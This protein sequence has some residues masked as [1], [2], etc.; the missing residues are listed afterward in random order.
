MNGEKLAFFLVILFLSIAYGERG[1]F[2]QKLKIKNIY[3]M[4]ELKLWELH[5]WLDHNL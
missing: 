5:P 2:K 3:Q 1:H 4:E